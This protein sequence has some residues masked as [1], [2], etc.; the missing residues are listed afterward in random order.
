MFELHLTVLRLCDINA[1]MTSLN[2][3]LKTT[4]LRRYA[5]EIF[6]IN[7]TSAMHGMS[8]YGTM[9]ISPKSFAYSPASK[10]HLGRYDQFPS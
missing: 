4:T 6:Q 10:R 3:L 5:L 1:F 7:C 8:V 2:N 9:P